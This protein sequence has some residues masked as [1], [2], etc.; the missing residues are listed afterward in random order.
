M[1]PSS[2][3]HLSCHSME[4]IPSDIRDTPYISKKYVSDSLNLNGAVEVDG[5]YVSCGPLSS[6]FV[7]NSVECYRS[8]AK[9]RVSKLFSDKDSIKMAVLSKLEEINKNIVVKNSCEMHIIICNKFG[10]FLHRTASI[11]TCG[12]QRLFTVHSCNHIMS[13]KIMRK[14]KEIEGVLSNKWV[15]HFFDPNKTVFVARSEVLRCEEFLDQSKFSLRMF[16]DKDLY[17]KYFKV[18]PE[19]VEETECAVL[20]YSDK[21]EASFGFS[22]LE[23]LSQDGISGCMIFH[24]MN[25]NIDSLDIR[26]IV[27]S[28]SFST[29]SSDARK[30]IFFARSSSGVFALYLAMS[31]NKYNSIKSYNDFLEGLSSDE[32]LSLLPIIIKSES[33]EGVPALLIAMQ[34]NS[35][36]S[37]NAFGSLIDRLINLRLRMRID[38]FCNMLFDILLAERKDGSSAI[39]AALHKNNAGAIRAFGSLLD[40]IFILKDD[41]NSRRLADIIFSLLSHED[42][43]K[44]SALFFALANGHSNAVRAFSGLMDK[45][46]ILRGHIPDIDITDMITKLLMSSHDGVLGLF[47]ALKRGHADTISAFSELMEKLFILRG[48]IPDIDIANIVCRLLMPSS[49]G[50]TGLFFALQKG[51]A[52]AILAWGELIGKFF[53][54]LSSCLPKDSFDYMML[55]ILEARGVDGDLGIF[56]PLLKNNIDVMVAYSSLL[57]YASKEV[58]RKIFCIKSDSGLPLICVLM[59]LGEPET[60]MAFGCF[61]KS[62]SYDEQIELLPELLISKNNAGDPAL[63]LAMQEGRDNCIS[64][65]ITLVE[66]QLMKIRERMP[67]D[68]FTNLVLDLALAKRSDGISALHMGMY[69]NRAS[70]IG[71]YSVLLERVSLLLK[72]TISDD[73]LVRVIFELLKARTSGG[74]DGLFTALERGNTCSVTAFYF[75]LD[76]FLSLKGCVEDILLAGMVFDLLMCKSGGDSIPGLFVAMKNGHHQVID[77]FVELLEKLILFK[78]DISAGYFNNMLLEIV[79]SSRSDGVSG[80]FIALEN[81]FSEVIKSYTPLLKLIPKDELA[82]VLAAPSSSGVPAALFAGKEA[83]EVYF[84]MISD[85]PTKTIYALHSRLGSARRSVEDILTGDRDLDGKYK[86]LLEK[87]K[88]LARSSRQDY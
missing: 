49:D 56:K 33:P 36:Q 57:V 43:G 22:T 80:L 55:N 50:V 11:M 31:Q 79:L 7:I 28:K 25:N 12:E 62:L 35:I 88:E 2:H 87:V 9:L 76:K 32:Q 54:L 73:K 60:F 71:A 83:L 17:R 68:D 37:I 47:F 72:G 42:R 86:L 46:F 59:L 26:E 30:E 13:F 63:F 69:K 19:F 82:N 81:N 61:L 14:T 84:A 38:D 18:N 77:S 34:E 24:L 8:N 67:H 52:D 65:Y 53:T 27:R 5:K 51:Y 16:I 45:L 78:N 15:V 64:A 85:L 21:R 6:L 40:R 3:V 70:T 4:V 29:L 48:H 23:T 58:R 39:H 44:K 74:I 75:L 1:N 41:V 66:A 20:E 10:D